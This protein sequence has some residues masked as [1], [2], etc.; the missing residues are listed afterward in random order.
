[1]SKAMLILDEMPKYCIGCPFKFKADSISLGNFTYQ[2]LFRCKF[3]PE[4]L[5]ED[6]GDEVFLNDFMWNRKP[7]WCPLREFKED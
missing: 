3:E 1:M 5:S 4:G 7:C 2:E 6:D